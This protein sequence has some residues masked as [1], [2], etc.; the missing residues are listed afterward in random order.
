MPG[1]F[2]IV[3]ASFELYWKWPVFQWMQELLSVNPIIQNKMWKYIEL[4]SCIQYNIIYK[5]NDFYINNEWNNWCGDVIMISKL[6]HYCSDHSELICHIILFVSCFINVNFFV[7]F[8]FAF[9]FKNIIYALRRTNSNI[10]KA[11]YCCLMIL[12]VL[13]II[14]NV[15]YL[16]KSYCIV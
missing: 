6:K 1:A 14:M 5:R 8:A 13:I 2:F 9:C 15:F 3:T 11:F 7:C 16:I 12:Y 4:V 10:L